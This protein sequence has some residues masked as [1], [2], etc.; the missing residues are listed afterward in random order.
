[1]ATKNA[2]VVGGYMDSARRAVAQERATH[3]RKVDNTIIALG[4]AVLIFGASLVVISHI[5]RKEHAPI[6]QVQK[7][8]APVQLRE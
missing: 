2:S 6:P 7:V 8:V 1:M 5:Q 4:G 3:W